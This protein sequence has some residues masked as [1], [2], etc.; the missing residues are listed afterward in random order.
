MFQA[1]FE[2]NDFQ[3]SCEIIARTGGNIKLAKNAKRHGTRG[4]VSKRNGFTIREGD[5][6]Q[7]APVYFA[8]IAPVGLLGS[9]PTPHENPDY[10]RR[11]SRG[12]G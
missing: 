12:E 3:I 11:V 2:P 6:L 8:Y 10:W 5:A 9:A 4:P 1:F 7:Y